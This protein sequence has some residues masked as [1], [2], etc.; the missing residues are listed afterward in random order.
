SLDT[1]FTVTLDRDT[2]ARFEGDN[3]EIFVALLGSAGDSSAVSITVE[4]VD[5]EDAAVKSL[6]PIIEVLGTVP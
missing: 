5:D 2:N 3:L 1:A 4:T 6:A